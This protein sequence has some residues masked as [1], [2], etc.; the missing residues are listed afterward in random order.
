MYDRIFAATLLVLSGLIAWTAYHFE[1][2]FQYE[3]LGPKAFPLILSVLLGSTALW[4]F[5]KPD[6]N[7]WHPTKDILLKLLAGFIIMLA[8]AFIFERLGF[9][10]ATTIVG[11]VF[12]WLFGQ[13]PLHAGLYALILSVISYFLLKELMELNVP[14]GTMFGG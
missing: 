13:K 11:G 14:V 12:S 2:A 10:L 1:V 4:L 6:T 3:P 8:Y 7:H 9:V 5:V